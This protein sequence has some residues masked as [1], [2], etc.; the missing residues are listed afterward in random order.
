[1]EE[2]GKVVFL[3][4]ILLK[5]FSYLSANQLGKIAV[6]CKQWYRVSKAPE[7][8]KRHVLR[9]WPSQ[10]FLYENINMRNLEW[11]KVFQELHQ[12][13]WFSPDEMKYFICCKT[14]SDELASEEIRQTMFER[15]AYVSQKWLQVYPYEHDD[16]S[17]HKNFDKNAELYFDTTL[18][19]WVFLDRRRGYIGD[20]FPSQKLRMLKR[21]KKTRHIRPYQVIPSCLVLYRW[22]C[23]FR[24]YATAEDGLTFYRIWR[25]KLRHLETGMIFEIYD[26]K[27][28]MNT[29]FSNGMPGNIKFRD[30]ALELL[31]ILSHPHFIMHPLGL[32]PLLSKSSQ[33]LAC[34]TAGGITKP[35]IS[36]ERRMRRKRRFQ[37]Q[38]PAFKDSKMPDADKSKL[39]NDVCDND[40]DGTIRERRGVRRKLSP[41]PIHPHPVAPTSP[42]GNSSSSLFSF[43][44]RGYSRESSC[45]SVLSDTEDSERSER[46]SDLESECELPEHGYIVNCEY[47][48]ITTHSL[49]IE[50]QHSLQASV[51]DGWMVT[52]K[53]R[54]CN[55][56]L[57][58]NAIEGYWYFPADDDTDAS[59]AGAARMLSNLQ[60]VSPL[61]AGCHGRSASD[62][63]LPGLAMPDL[64][65]HGRSNSDVGL[66]V[67]LRSMMRDKHDAN[68]RLKTSLTSLPVSPEPKMAHS[69][70]LLSPML[71][72]RLAP[73]S[74]TGSQYSIS[75]I[76]TNASSKFEVSGTHEMFEPL[77]SI[78]SSLALYRLIC[79]F[80]LNC[81]MY[82]STEDTSV[83]A[84]KLLHKKTGGIVQF[85]DYNGE[86]L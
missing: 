27:A 13:S 56:K 21:N 39:R 2:E 55:I 72:P 76:G 57:S 11:R 28:A 50:E 64:P 31:Q 80:D 48:I 20:L 26:W 63:S 15:M 74:A 49:D 34:A 58:F 54:P 22:L 78:P 7:L 79:L 36:A 60:K 61:V 66:P 35:K 6:V 46:E 43:D 18:L 19:K 84:V 24:S 85:S 16:D 47:F 59:L 41:K 67:D 86:T 38:S 37:M 30:D 40:E 53:T 82:R 81:S 10:R 9:K 23:L 3:D 51:S 4:E 32:Q 75:S 17:G 8:W 1:M 65:F 68:K 70:D 5:V 77:E 52:H 73:S 71:S 44:R 83:W 42:R 25:F 29:T 45:S 12:K 62:L 33:Y 69:D 14:V